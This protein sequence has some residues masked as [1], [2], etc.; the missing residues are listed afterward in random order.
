MPQ[1][2]RLLKAT[3]ST[4]VGGQLEED[5]FALRGFF[6]SPAND[7]LVNNSEAL[8]Y[9]RDRVRRYE[10]VQDARR[11]LGNPN[12]GRPTQMDYQM[13]GVPIPPGAQIPAR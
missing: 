4:V 5:F 9:L 3:P 1:A 2:E 10:I 13:R 11:E 7:R 6:F 12:P 8:Q